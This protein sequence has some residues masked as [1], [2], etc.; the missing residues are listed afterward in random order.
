MLLEYGL[1]TF[2]ELSSKRI[3]AKNSKFEAFTRLSSHESRMT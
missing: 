2:I 1:G 3:T